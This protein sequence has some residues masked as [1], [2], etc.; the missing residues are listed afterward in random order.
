M[1]NKQP[2][3]DELLGAQTYPSDDGSTA[4]TPEDTRIAAAMQL[5][6]NADIEIIGALLRS[7]LTDS[8]EQVRRAVYDVIL[9]YEC[10]HLS[11]AASLLVTVDED[12]WLRQDAIRALERLELELAIEVSQTMKN[13]PDPYVAKIATRILQESKTR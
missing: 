7:L 10:N 11:I 3:I 13:D 12:D 9:G 8:E 5:A 4:L 1:K 2:V 6:G